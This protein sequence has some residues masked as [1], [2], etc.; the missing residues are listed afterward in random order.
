MKKVKWKKGK[1]KRERNEKG[2]VGYKTN[3]GCKNI[4]GENGRDE[5]GRGKGRQRLL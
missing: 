4:E 3:E 1:W 5:W 2:K